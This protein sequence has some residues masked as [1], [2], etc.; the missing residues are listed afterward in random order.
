[1]GENKTE[2]EGI[3]SDL[4][5]PGAGG[6]YSGIW[7]GGKQTEKPD[8]SEQEPEIAGDLVVV[9]AHDGLSLFTIRRIRRIVYDA[10]Y[11]AFPRKYKGKNEALPGLEDVRKGTAVGA[12]LENS[13][14]RS[15]FPTPGC[16]LGFRPAALHGFRRGCRF[17]WLAAGCRLARYSRW[18]GG[19]ARSF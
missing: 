2:G 15:Q 13:G 4:E 7:F 6:L 19:R 11:R 17:S 18:S 8:G 16:Q 12:L 9:E 5:Q 14:S 3:E 10:Y 1:M